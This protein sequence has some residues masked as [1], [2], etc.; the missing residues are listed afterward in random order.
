MNL[1]RRLMRASA[2]SVTCVV[3]AL[4]V[5]PGSAGFAQQRAA[6]GAQVAPAAG[7]ELLRIMDQQR[8]D[9]TT[10]DAS[11]QRY[12][13]AAESLATLYRRLNE[14]ASAVVKAA[15][16]TP[17]RAG[18]GSLQAEIDD[19]RDAQTRFDRQFQ[20][21]QQVMQ[22]ESR[23]FT[24]LSHVMKTRHDTAKNAISNVR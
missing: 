10:L 21:L 6:G 8:T 3:V 20:A 1:W 4:A 16:A 24:A 22:D 14:H 18:G 15:A 7:A 11:H 23:R 13:E 19:M 17:G 9:L 2:A 5:P 12:R